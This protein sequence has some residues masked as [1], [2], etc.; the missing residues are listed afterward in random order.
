MTLLKIFFLYAIFFSVFIA[1]WNE[2][3]FSSLYTPSFEN[4]TNM[5]SMIKIGHLLYSTNNGNV[6][7]VRILDITDPVKTEVSFVEKGIINETIKVT[8]QG[9]YIETYLSKDVIRGEGKGIITAQNNGEI[10]T[11]QA[12]DSGKL[13]NSNETQTYHG[14]IFF[15][16]Y[17]QGKLSFL[18][19]K[20]GLYLIEIGD[21]GS[22]S[23]H[24]WEWK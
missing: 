20:V 9:T 14:I 12:Y 16:S 2:I 15:N 24:I 8:N 1:S 7:N 17:S 10:V 23:R 22:Y 13:L 21:D 19:N 18:D 5:T 4:S 6:T 3:S 11:W